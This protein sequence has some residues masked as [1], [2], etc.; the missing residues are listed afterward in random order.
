MRKWWLTLLVVLA[1]VGAA[2]SSGDDDDDTSTDDEEET[3]DDEATGG[4]EGEG[5]TI[6]HYSMAD[7]DLERFM[8]V[9]INEMGAVGSGDGLNIV[10]LVDRSAEYEVEEHP[11]DL[12]DYV[13][14]KLIAVGD[15]TAE[16]LEE[17]GDLNLGDP[18]TIAEFIVQGVEAAP[19]ENYALIISDHGG[20]WTG[21]GPDEGSGN[22][23]LDLTELRDGIGEGLEAA[24]IDKLDL[25]GFD[26]C[27]MA[28]YEVATTLQPIADRLVAA[29]EKEPGH[30]W[31]Y[32][33]LQAVRDNPAT[34]VDELGTVL[35]D[36]FLAQA[37]EQGQ[38]AEVTLSLMDLTQMP[39]LDEAMATFTGALVE[40]A[41]EV[42]PAVGQAHASS[43]EYGKSPDPSQAIWSYDLGVLAAAIGIEALDVSD[44]ADAVQRALNDVVLYKVE[45]P[46][47][48]DHTGMAIYFP[49]SSFF[50]GRY[51]E[52]PETAG[53]WLSF[54]Q[55]YYSAGEALPEAEQATFTSDE[56]TI[57]IDEEG[58]TIE[59]AFDAAL[60]D[61]VSSAKIEYGI[62][63]PD[64]SVIYTGDETASVAD[65]GSGLVSGFYDLT[66]FS[67]TDGQDSA[68]AYL[69]LASDD[70]EPGFTLDVPLSYYAPG[71]D[72]ASGT[73][74]KEI[75]L[76]VIVD[77]EQNVVQE[78][79]YSVDP[80]SGT[81]GEASLEPDGLLVPR[82]PVF[83]AEGNQFWASTT[84][85]GL[86]ADLPSIL[87]EFPRLASGTQLLVEL[88]ITDF[89]GN[90]D[91]VAAQVTIP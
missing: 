57:T 21:M 13:G 42:S 8:M 70:E 69:S 46:Q 74:D 56:A 11:L 4:G 1:L 19:A 15:G 62:I 3:T 48:A 85:V 36:G 44:Q 89:A 61:N 26:A 68:L 86:F 90:T 47:A 38:A 29:T 14:A 81:Y 80:E 87:Y 49:Q 83:D 9:D 63:Q 88:V 66:E 18:A 53:G 79:Y 78:T 31:D 10:A 64:G 16:I 35:I 6:L 41:A 84:D 40:R 43:L 65:D 30:G 60:T 50:D 2:C 77:D 39:A 91:R 24:G 17:K 25:L 58:L 20:G 7:T 71:N 76:T 12:G 59:A 33:V 37:E 28:T 52:I 27:L 34:T 23:V 54:L 22:D 45:G 75:L 32:R 5:W 51:T 55:S 72:I 73:P 82:L 67:L